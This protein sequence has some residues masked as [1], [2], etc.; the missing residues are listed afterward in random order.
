MTSVGCSPSAGGARRGSA[1]ARRARPRARQAARQL[2]ATGCSCSGPGASG[3]GRRA[4]GGCGRSAPAARGSP[5]GRLT[6]SPT[7]AI[8]RGP[9]TGVPHDGQKRASLPCSAPQREQTEMPGSRS[10]VS[11]RRSSSACSRAR[12]SRVDGGQRVR[13]CRATSVLVDLRE[14][15]LVE[16]EAAEVAEAQLAHAAQVAQAPAQAAALAEA[17]AAGTG[18]WPAGISVRGARLGRRSAPRARPSA[19]PG[20]RQPEAGS[21]TGPRWAAPRS[22]PPAR[23]ARCRPRWPDARRAGGGWRAAGPSCGNGTRT[24]RLDGQP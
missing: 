13:A 16:D 9:W 4:A 5:A 19:A 7:S 11:G 12:S 24:R 8:A 6:A 17:R 18:S 3:L 14:A 15:V 10:S 1:R 20:R 21:T 23:P 2:G 22:A